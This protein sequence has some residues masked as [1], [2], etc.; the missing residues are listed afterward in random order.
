MCKEYFVDINRIIATATTKDNDAFAMVNVTND[1]KISYM[2]GNSG[3][4]NLIAYNVCVVTA[5]IISFT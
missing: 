5:N 1:H 3:L 4:N 2:H